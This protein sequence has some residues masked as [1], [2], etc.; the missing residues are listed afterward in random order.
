M[1]VDVDIKFDQAKLKRIERMLRGIPGAMPKVVT[2][3]INKTAGPAKTQIGKEIRTEIN[4]TT[5]RVNQRLFLQKAT[6][7]NW[8]AT[9][10]I[11]KRRLPL[12]SF[13]AKQIKKGVS[14]NILKSGG[15]KKIDSAF[16]QTMSS[17]HVGVFRRKSDQ[18]LPIVEMFGP[19]IGQVFDKSVSI[20]KRVIFQAYKRLDHNIEHELNY[21]LGRFKK[22]GA[23]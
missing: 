16:I 4:T 6:Y 5:K 23:A 17:G 8:A 15:R 1:P 12:M 11:S 14:Y 3:A 7:T 20:A 18:R 9:I 2:R 21:V 19:S 10:S 13:G 22:R